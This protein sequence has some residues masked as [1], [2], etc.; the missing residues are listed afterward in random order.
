MISLCVYYG[1]SEWDGP[2]SLKD[3]LEIPEKIEP[4][5]SDYRMNLVQVRSS[6]ELCFSDPDVNM[7]FD[8]S[9][10][11]YARA[12]TKINEVYRDHNI[13]ADLGLVIGAITESQ[14]LIDHALESEQKGGQINMCNA[15]EELRQGEVLSNFTLSNVSFV[16]SFK[17]FRLKW[18]FT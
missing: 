13:P 18:N 16:F 14:K 12:Y 9:R 1:E 4:L 15:L 2:S 7:V 5:V 10:L 11:I 17:P 6:G 3:M 8:V